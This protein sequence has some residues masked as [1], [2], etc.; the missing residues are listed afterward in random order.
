[1]FDLLIGVIALSVRA[2]A[3]GSH[4]LLGIDRTVEQ[5]RPSHFCRSTRVSSVCL[6]LSSYSN[7][8]CSSR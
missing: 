7:S 1:M 2:G 5:F 3:G 6:S 8:A 4:K